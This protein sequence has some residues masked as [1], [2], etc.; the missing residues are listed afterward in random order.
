[1][2]STYRPK[3]KFYWLL[4]P[5]FHSQIE[6]NSTIPIIPKPLYGIDPY[7]IIDPNNVMNWIDEVDPNDPTKKNRAITTNG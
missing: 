6:N 2:A 1:M 5:R 4:H 7:W 3:R